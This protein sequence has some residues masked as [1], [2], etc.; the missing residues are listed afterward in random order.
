MR[1]KVGSS[2]VEQAGRD[3]V[4]RQLSCIVGYVGSRLFLFFKLKP[5]VETS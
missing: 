1:C 4:K 2:G 3:L 5:T